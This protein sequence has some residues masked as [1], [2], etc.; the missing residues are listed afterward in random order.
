MITEQKFFQVKRFAQRPGQY[1]GR[2]AFGISVLASSPEEAL[3]ISALY[4]NLD[5]SRDSDLTTTFEIDPRGTE[6]FDKLYPIHIGCDILTSSGKFIPY[7]L[8]NPEGVKRSK[9]AHAKA[10]ASIDFS[11][12]AK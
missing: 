3:E 10:M 6:G 5:N 1:A 4:G 11:I 2:A 8:L 12:G 7:N 9:E